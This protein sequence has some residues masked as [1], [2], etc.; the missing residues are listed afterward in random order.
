MAASFANRS[1]SFVD[2]GK[3]TSRLSWSSYPLVGISRLDLIHAQL[4]KCEIELF[5]SDT[6]GSQIFKVGIK[7]VNVLNLSTVY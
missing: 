3:L 1:C 2:S 5:L 4:V 6:K 7:K